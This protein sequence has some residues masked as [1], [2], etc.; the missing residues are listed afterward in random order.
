MIVS[1]NLLFESCAC[2]LAIELLLGRFFDLDDSV[3]S[4]VDP[5][6]MNLARM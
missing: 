3:A 5:L 1:F 2:N 4:D 6:D